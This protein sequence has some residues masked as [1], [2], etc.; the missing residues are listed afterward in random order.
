MKVNTIYNHTALSS[1]IITII[2][3]LDE[4][5]SKE[6]TKNLAK[7]LIQYEHLPKDNF[8]CWVAYFFAHETAYVTNGHM[9]KPKSRVTAHLSDL[10]F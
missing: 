3:Y 8:P 10:A 5:M 9:E 1:R 6:V 2:R 7:Q 4:K